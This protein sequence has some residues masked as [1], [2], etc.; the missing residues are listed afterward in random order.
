MNNEQHLKIKK[1]LKITGGIV[2]AAGL[3]LAVI[4][5]ADFFA[6]FGGD[7]QPRFFWCTFLGLP[8]FAAGLSMLLWGFHREIAQ[9]AK[10]EI[11]PV[12][13]EAIADLT[14]AVADM[15]RAA[16][17]EVSLCPHCGAKNNVGA[18]FCSECGAPLARTCA[19]CG[20]KNEAGAKFCG[21][22]G[23]PL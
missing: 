22:C 19:A 21:G 20:A 15:A 14:P 2:F 9:Y 4:G 7:G 23:K 12:A 6:A 18:K 1:I 16:R 17:E 13:G 11:T 3:I 10:N 8:L 5:F